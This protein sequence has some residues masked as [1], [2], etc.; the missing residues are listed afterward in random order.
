MRRTTNSA[1]AGLLFA[2]DFLVSPARTGSLVPSSRFLVRR[3][4]RLVD[5]ERAR[6]VVEFG[7]G[8][9]C[10]T[11]AILRRMRPDARLI[12]LELNRRFVER[13]ERTIAD[14]RLT[15]RHASACEIR[16]ELS[17]AHLCAA[18]AIVS[19]LPL[20]N[21]PAMVRGRILHNAHA[22]LREGGTLVMF[23][24]RLPMLRVVRSVFGPI[25][26][27]YEPLN[28]PPAHVFLGVRRGSRKG[29]A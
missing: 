15:V 3:M 22:A 4:L 23:Q 12:A 17:R 28:L 9:G 6:V 1:A 13:L 7:P 25:H 26:R 18:D 5:W 11:R 2:R 8:M 10:F 29:A 16:G 20:L 21:M 27:E 24:Y 14:P 19:S